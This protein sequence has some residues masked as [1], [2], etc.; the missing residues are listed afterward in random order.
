MSALYW[1]QY[2][3]NGNFKW[4]G[5]S[6]IPLFRAVDSALSRATFYL[7]PDQLY[8]CFLCMAMSERFERPSRILA[9]TVDFKST[10]L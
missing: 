10:P 6:S 3:L 2:L 1:N 5:I 8:W 9:D 4:V 7:R